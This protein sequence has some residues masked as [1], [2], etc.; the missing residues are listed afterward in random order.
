[1]TESLSQVSER[2]GFSSDANFNRAVKLAFGRPPGSLFKTGYRAD[3]N[4]EARRPVN[5]PMLDWFS[6]EQ[7]GVL[8]S[9][10]AGS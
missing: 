8:E 4:G 1:M 2:W 7:K 3:M 9:Y 5:D 10:I 6:V